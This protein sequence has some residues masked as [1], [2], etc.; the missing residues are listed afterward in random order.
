MKRIIVLFGLAIIVALAPSG[1]NAVA[2]NISPSGTLFGS[3][4]NVF[5]TPGAVSDDYTLNLTDAPAFLISITGTSS[6]SATTPGVPTGASGIPDLTISILD[7]GG[8]PVLTN[9]I[10]SISLP[11]TAFAN[12]FSYYLVSGSGYTIHVGGTRG[13]TGGSYSF[14]LNAQALPV[15]GAFLLFG[16]GLAALGFAGRAGRKARKTI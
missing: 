1:A 16:S 8:A 4:G 2:I 14:D 10:N 12:I 6:F 15:P 7:I 13:T 3:G 5:S 9:S 11:H